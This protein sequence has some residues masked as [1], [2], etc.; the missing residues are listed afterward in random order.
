MYSF[1]L[2]LHSLLRWV[3]VILAVVTVVRAFGGWFGKKEWTTLDGRLGMLSSISIDLQ[4]LVGLILYIFLSPLTKGAFQDFGAAMSDQVLRFWAVEHIFWMVLA[5][6]LMHVGRAIS[7]RAVGATSKHRRAA[8]FFGLATLAI[9]F[10]IPWP[11]LSY[12]R[13][14]I[15]LVTLVWP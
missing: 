12:G 9:L 3:V 2:T 15:R 11:F 13:P 10:A 14:L 4:L 7:K 8:I 1:V 5:L 6:I